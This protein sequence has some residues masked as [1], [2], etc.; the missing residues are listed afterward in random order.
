V[1]QLST[2]KSFDQAL[3]LDELGEVEEA[4]RAYQDA[5]KKGDRVADAYCN[6]GILESRNNSIKA[7]GCFT[8]SLRAAP[9]HFQSHYN[10]GNLYSEEKSYTLARL[11]YGIAIEIAPDFPNAYYNL[12]LVL[13]MIKEYKEAIEVLS[14]YQSMASAEELGKTKELIDGLRNSLIE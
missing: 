7:I 6:L 9:R 13:A 10:L 5:I 3:T 11:H 4:K 2:G 8:Q 1:V 14:K 12:G